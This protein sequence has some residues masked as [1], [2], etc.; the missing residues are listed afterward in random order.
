MPAEIALLSA[1]YVGVATIIH[2][3]I[4]VLSGSAATF[5]ETSPHTAAIRK[6]LAIV[7]ALAACW[8]FYATKLSG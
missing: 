2:S 8:F 6:G 5:L 3:G 1:V 4:A 7:I